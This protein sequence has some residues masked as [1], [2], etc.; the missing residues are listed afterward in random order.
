MNVIPKGSK[1]QVKQPPPII[2]TVDALKFDED[3]HQFLYH[4]TFEKD[5][6]PQALWLTEAQ[7]DQVPA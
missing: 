6:E 5:G 1:V 3:L 2:G 7:L 4:V